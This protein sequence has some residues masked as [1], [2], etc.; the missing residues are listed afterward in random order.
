MEFWLLV[1]V[2]AVLASEALIRLPA[3]ATIKAVS[4]ASQKAMRTLKSGRISDHWKERV[5]PAYARQIG[6]GSVSFF[7]MLCLGL[8]PVLMAGLLYSGG[9]AAWA[10]ALIRPEVV[11]V[12]CMVS[13]GYIVIRKRLVRV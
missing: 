12:L 10:V 7:V 8:L 4:Q 2:A 11:A 5:L 9:L 13:L 6:F 1:V 3:L